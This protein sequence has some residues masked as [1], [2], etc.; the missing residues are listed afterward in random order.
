MTGLSST[1]QEL[2][3]ATLQVAVPLRV[4][5]LRATPRS[6]WPDPTG[7]ADDLAW[8]GDLLM[9]PSAARG[10]AGRLAVR[11]ATAVAALLLESR[12]G[13]TVFGVH[14]CDPRGY[15]CVDPECPRGFRPPGDDPGGWLAAAGLL[16][17]GR[18]PRATWSQPPELAALTDEQLA[19]WYDDP[20]E[21]G[22]GPW[23][24]PDCEAR[25]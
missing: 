20:P 5:E 3:A 11:L 17:V 10:E 22:C 15:A 9:F 13:V 8:R 23:C 6:Q 21:R 24:G 4:A 12:G 25:S 19:G 16:G 18:Q 1:T 2:L 7:L 14:W